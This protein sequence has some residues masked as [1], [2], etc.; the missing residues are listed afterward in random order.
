MKL[1]GRK[2]PIIK[3][4]KDKIRHC[5]NKDRSHSAMFF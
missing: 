2:Q 4:E 5:S 1:K 3:L